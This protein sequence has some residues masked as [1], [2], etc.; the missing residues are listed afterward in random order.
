M[1][2]S[3]VLLSGG[4]D[5]TVNLYLAAQKSQVLQVLTF[6]YGQKA[7]TKEL[8]SASKLCQKLNIPHQV[9]S[10][11]FFSQIGGSSLTDHS[12]VIP[13]GKD[14]SIDDMAVSQKTA[15]SVW[16]PNRNGIFLNIAAG[17]AESL[18]AD[19]VIPGFNIEEAATFPDNSKNFLNAL[20]HSFSFST[21]N[22][23][24]T[25]CFTT[26]LNKTEI[27]QLGIKLGVDWGLMWPCYH[28][29]EKWCGQCESCQR[30]KRAFR[31]AQVD[32]SGWFNEWS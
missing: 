9:I 18:K 19:W 6:D 10:L 15:K 32:A 13:T 11:S 12:Q 27:V 29:N 24:V 31:Q 3:V 1:K 16:V 2:R 14:V 5:S 21:A 25:Q 20:D 23:V 8:Q 30:S 7:R 22:Q 26:D 28:E 17:F 4:L